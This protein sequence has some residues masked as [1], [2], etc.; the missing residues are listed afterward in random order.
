M[1]G[2]LVTAAGA[3]A[4]RLARQ[5]VKEI[6]QTGHEARLGFRTAILNRSGRRQSSGSTGRGSHQR[7]IYVAV[8]NYR[9]AH[10]NLVDEKHHIRAG[11]GPGIGRGI[12]RRSWRVRVKAEWRHDDGVYG[13]LRV[14]RGSRGIRFL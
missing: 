5:L 11:T 2:R 14:K 6:P 8:K 4:R 7:R 12:G 3:R 9:G 13:F 1:T 10:A